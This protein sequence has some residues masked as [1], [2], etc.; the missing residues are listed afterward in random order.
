M[1][2]SNF[3]AIILGLMMGC[4]G[5]GFLVHGVLVRILTMPDGS[6]VFPVLL[7][8][9]T[10]VLTLFAFRKI[11]AHIAAVDKHIAVVDKLTSTK[12]TRI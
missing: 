1:M 6:L 11:D 7:L 8:I 12:T 10:F 9:L 2:T 5:L 4:F 3:R